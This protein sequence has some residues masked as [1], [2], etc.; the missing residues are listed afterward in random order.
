MFTATPDFQISL[1]FFLQTAVFELQAILRQVHQMTLKWPGTLKDQTHQY[2]TW[3]HWDTD[4]FSKLP[5]LGRSSTY[6]HSLPHG[7]GIDPIFALLA[8]AFEIWAD[9][10]NWNIWAWNFAIGQSCASC[11]KLHIFI[12]SLYHKGLKFNPFFTLRAAISEIR[13]FKIAIFGHET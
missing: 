13:F 6:T 10:Q 12:L 7:I 3:V 9:F 4:R 2:K 11:T 8:A 1:R 5:H